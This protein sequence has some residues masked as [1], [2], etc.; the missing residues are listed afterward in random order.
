[1]TFAPDAGVIRQVWGA[2]I[3]MIVAMSADYSLRLKPQN[4]IIGL[5]IQHHAEALS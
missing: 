2:P 5:P 1:M 4:L 3:H